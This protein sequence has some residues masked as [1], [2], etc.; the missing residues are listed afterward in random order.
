MQLP[1][2]R[3][4]IFSPTFKGVVDIEIGSYAVG[5]LEVEDDKSTEYVLRVDGVSKFAISAGAATT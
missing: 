4:E 3:G 5:I 2:R 1:L